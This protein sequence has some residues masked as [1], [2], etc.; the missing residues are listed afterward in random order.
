MRVL[1]SVLQG[2]GYPGLGTRSCPASTPTRWTVCLPFT[3][4]FK[5]IIILWSEPVMRQTVLT[6]SALSLQDL[7][8]KNLVED[9]DQSQELVVQG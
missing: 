7:G 4:T 2:A 9:T 6:S 5:V 3:V 1:P 8:G